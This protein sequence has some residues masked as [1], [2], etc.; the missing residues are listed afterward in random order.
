LHSS[1]S[2]L[3][4][5]FPKREI[6]EH[7]TEGMSFTGD[8]LLI[9]LLFNNLIE[10]AIKYSPADKA[11]E[12]RLK[13]EDGRTRFEIIDQGNGIPDAEKKRVFQKFY[14]SGHENTRSTKG[15]G[16]GLYLSQKIAEDHNTTIE[17]SDNKP[18]GSIFTIEF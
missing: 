2:N 18:T 17:I 7:I 4:A 14:R 1:V 6:R 10:N 16:L 15:T 8:A 11:V 9:Q 3:R 13:R 5:R 12:I